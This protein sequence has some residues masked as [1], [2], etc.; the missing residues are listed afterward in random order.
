MIIDNVFYCG[1]CDICSVS[2]L[3]DNA[4]VLSAVQSSF[5][6]LNWHEI[7]GLRLRLERVT[8]AHRAALADA[9]VHFCG[10]GLLGEAVLSIP[11][12]CCHASTSSRP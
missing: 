6:P 9:M 10:A 12:S 11:M 3:V 1:M 4:N 8:F 7:I 2:A 5:H